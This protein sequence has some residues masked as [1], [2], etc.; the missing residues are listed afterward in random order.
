[1]QFYFFFSI[2]IFTNIFYFFALY[3]LMK[4]EIFIFSCTFIICWAG[5]LEKIFLTS[6]ITWAKSLKLFNLG[7]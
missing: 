4:I 3:Y 7:Q 2:D 6:E 1:M 5:K